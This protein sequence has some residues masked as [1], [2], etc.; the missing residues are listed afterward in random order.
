MSKWDYGE[1]F[2][3]HPINNNEIVIFENNS[4]LKVHN[5]FDTLPDFMK[6]ADIIF[7]DPPCSKGN[8]N[9]F[10]TKADRTDY[11]NSYE[12]FTIR[13]WECI[14]E[15]KPKRLFIEV[16]KSNKERFIKECE[17]RY[18][19]VTLYQS[20]YYNNPKNI[21]WII[22][23]SNE[24]SDYPFENMDEE[25]VIE[26]ICAN[27]DYNCIGDLCMGKGLVGYYAYK[28]NKKFVG[29]ELNHKRLSVAIERIVNLGGKY[30]KEDSE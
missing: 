6:E 12:P 28:N 4:K 9:S 17:Q 3:R 1:A 11:Q 20:M 25:K 22:V 13:F 29:T 2:K 27:E 5:L 26:W 8:I 14:D 15:L 24:P 10:Y 7:V 23:C 30:I 21:C 18:K 19:N 16:F